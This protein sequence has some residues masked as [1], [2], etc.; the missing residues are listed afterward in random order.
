MYSTA[1]RSPAFLGRLGGRRLGSYR[2][3]QAVQ[4]TYTR[5]RSLTGIGNGYVFPPRP[6]GRRRLGQD[7][8]DWTTFD[9]SNPA[10]FITD[11]SDFSAVPAGSYQTSVP[12]DIAAPFSFTLPQG[13]P[14]YPIDSV[15]T[16]APA[17][18]PGLNAPAP[19][20][21]NAGTYINPVTGAVNALAKLATGPV[22]APA[23]NPTAAWTSQT[24]PSLGVSNGT[25]LLG[26]GA[27]ALFA[28]SGGGGGGRR[29]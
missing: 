9:P 6:A 26:L 12:V 5:R 22:F 27:I 3:N 13:N 20:G 1:F 17:V 25:L 23:A 14:N 29:R 18:V 28:L 21:E 15:Y 10:T 19:V 16:P 24:N 7:S 4:R 11:T 2:P 8:T